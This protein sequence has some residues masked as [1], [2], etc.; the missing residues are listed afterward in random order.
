MAAP[1]LAEGIVA[2]PRGLL[3]FTGSAPLERVQRLRELGDSV[4]GGEGRLPTGPAEL[5]AEIV[6]AAKELLD[7]EEAAFFP[8]TPPSAGPVAYAPPPGEVE[9]LAAAV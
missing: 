7:C 3:R 9:W 4:L 1:R 5:V 8:H 2:I 6:E